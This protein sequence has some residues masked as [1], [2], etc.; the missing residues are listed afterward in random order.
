METTLDWAD[1]ETLRT[2]PDRTAEL[3][4]RIK[5]AGHEDFNRDDAI[6]SVGRAYVEGDLSDEA[7]EAI[8]DGL[9]TSNSAFLQEVRDAVRKYRRT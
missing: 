4:T 8:L 2:S 9:R 5:T 6:D 1:V 3:F 7:Y